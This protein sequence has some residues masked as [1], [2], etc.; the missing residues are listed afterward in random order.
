[1][2]THAFDFDREGLAVHA[3]PRVRGLH[4]SALW[5]IYAPRGAD[6]EGSARET[7]E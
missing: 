5:Q 4:R 7:E 2:R 6:F 1:M 3:E